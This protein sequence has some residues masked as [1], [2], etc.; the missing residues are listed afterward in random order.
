MESLYGMPVC[1][2]E[3]FVV[4]RLPEIDPDILIEATQADHAPRGIG[5][6]E[7]HRGRG[8]GLLYLFRICPEEL[9]GVVH[10]PLDG[11]LC[12]SRRDG[13][14]VPQQRRRDGK[15]ETAAVQ[16]DMEQR[17]IRRVPARGQE[18]RTFSG[19]R[20]LHGA[21]SILIPVY[22]A[23]KKTNQ[24]PAHHHPHGGRG[25]AA[26]APGSAEGAGP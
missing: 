20:P 22:R 4:D 16:R 15:R 24:D 25:R 5:L 7:S 6:P 1:D 9:C 19:V 3:G 26:G 18:E 12:L 17:P 21:L 2:W 11:G 23:M 14:A 13:Q 10:E 8:E